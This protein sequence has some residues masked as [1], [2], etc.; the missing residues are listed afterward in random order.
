MQLDSTLEIED[1]K[2]KIMNYIKDQRN[3][4]LR[5]LEFT[6]CKQQVG[7]SFDA[8]CIK[9]KQKADEADSCKGIKCVDT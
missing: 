9:L 8:Y 2:G 7:E 4:S 5:M 6:N 1:I 3:E